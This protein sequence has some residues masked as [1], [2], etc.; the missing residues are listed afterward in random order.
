MKLGMQVA[1]A[2]AALYYMWPQL[3]SPKRGRSP[4]FSAHVCR[5]EMAAWIKIPLGMEIGLGP[6]DIVLDGD[7]TPHPQATLC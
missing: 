5:G 2:L 6:R 4:R 1:S 3:P 7:P